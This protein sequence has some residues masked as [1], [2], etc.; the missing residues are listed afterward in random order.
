[1]TKTFEELAFS[2]TPMGELSLRRRRLSAQDTYIYE[3]KLGDEFLM[4]SLFTEG[5][6]ALAELSLQALVPNG[7]DVAVGGLGLGYTAA[8]VLRNPRVQSLYV[9]EKF[10]EVI[11]W[12]CKDVVPLGR[13]LTA[14]PRCHL[15]EGDF[16]AIFGVPLREE[17]AGIGG[18]KFHAILVDIDHSPQCLLSHAHESF[19]EPDGLRALAT[20]LHPGG[21]FA[22]WSNDPPDDKFLD[23]LFDVFDVS[24][25]KVVTFNNPLQNGTAASTI[26]I[27][28]TVHELPPVH[29]SQS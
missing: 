2:R 21:I 1:M 8:S 18:R 3:I 12:H 25:A 17:D 15:L 10:P 22:L 14:D 20:H 24:E 29:R 13:V 11:E 7:L 19:Y 6:T 5:E 27:A 28:R 4:S 9:I 23:V 26:Y 16:F